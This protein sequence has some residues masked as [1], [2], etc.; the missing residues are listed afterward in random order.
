M[1]GQSEGRCERCYD[2]KAEP[3]EAQEKRIQEQRERENSR[4]AWGMEK[5]KV[6]V[7]KA[8]SAWAKMMKNKANGPGD[9]MVSEMLWELPMESV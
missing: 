7:D 9:C 6:T 3:T 8:L 2:D 5:A 1:D 4:E